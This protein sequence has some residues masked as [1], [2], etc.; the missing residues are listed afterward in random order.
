MRCTNCGSELEDDA[1]FCTACGAKVETQIGQVPP[2][3]SVKEPGKKR[4]V[5]VTGILGIAVIAL[6][7]V[8]VFLVKGVFVTE[9]NRICNGRRLAHNDSD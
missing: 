3:Q 2:G 1:L 6:A 5:L 9:K 8:A 4:N 7:V